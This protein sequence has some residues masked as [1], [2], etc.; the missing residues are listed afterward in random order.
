VVLGVDEEDAGWAND[1]VVGVGA[2]AEGSQVVEDGAFSRVR[3]SAGGGPY[4]G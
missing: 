3:A 4:L 2:G 1:E